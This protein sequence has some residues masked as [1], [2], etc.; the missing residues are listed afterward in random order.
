[1][2]DIDNIQ[3]IIGDNSSGKTIF[4]KQIAIICI[5]AQIGF[6]IENY[7]I[8]IN[9]CFI[10]CFVPCQKAILCNFHYLITKFNTN[11]NIET[12]ASGL[13][14]EIRKL[15][16][17][18]MNLK[19]NQEKQRN[20][21]LI[22]G[23]IK[24]TVFEENLALSIAFIEYIILNSQ[25]YGVI[26]TKEIDLINN[27]KI[28]SNINF[29]KIQNHHLFNLKEENL[30]NESNMITLLEKFIAPSKL[31]KLIKRKKE[32]KQEEKYEENIENKYLLRLKECLKE[33]FILEISSMKTEE[34]YQIK[35]EIIKK[36]FK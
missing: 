12:N 35:S 1:M 20:L 11:D 27:L 33:L 26:S 32:Q 17:I 36:Y 10:G 13:S 16:N 21:L 31:I 30:K 29:L 6:K 18:L 19:K 5:L 34:K 8:F 24:S 7:F 4:L 25:T 15:S 28:Y 3:I 22:D 2:S 14:I 9:I 23:F